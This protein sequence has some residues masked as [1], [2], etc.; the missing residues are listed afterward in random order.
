MARLAAAGRLRLDRGLRAWVANA[1][2][3]ERISVI[4]VTE[5]IALTA[6]S[7]LGT[8]RDPGDQIIYATAV[9]GRAKLV[10]CDERIRQLDPARVI[11]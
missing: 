8:V 7:L 6:G 1:L 3:E 11:W 5:A 2:D 9:E 4:P 10:T